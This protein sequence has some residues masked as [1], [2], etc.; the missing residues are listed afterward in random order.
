MKVYKI[1]KQVMKQIELLVSNVFL[2]NITRE[3][4]YIQTYIHP[5]SHM[6]N[7]PQ[8]IKQEMKLKRGNPPQT[9]AAF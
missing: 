5:W 3:N 4:V 8:N 7:Q 9:K 6:C 2:T 1:E